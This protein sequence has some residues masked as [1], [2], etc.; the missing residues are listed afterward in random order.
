MK[1]VKAAFID[2]TRITERIVGGPHFISGW[3]TEDGKRM[4]SQDRKTMWFSDVVNTCWSETL[5]YGGH[6]L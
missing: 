6:K 5:N 2:P 4:F 1:L 3:M